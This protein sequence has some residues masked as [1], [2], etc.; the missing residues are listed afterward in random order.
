MHDGTKEDKKQGESI[1]ESNEI[2][3]T[4]VG[5]RQDKFSWAQPLKAKKKGEGLRNNCT[6][7]TEQVLEIMST[8]RLQPHITVQRKKDF[9]GRD[10][11]QRFRVLGG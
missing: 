8:G 11:G 1:C 10:F 6:G 4:T 2:L 7:K 9:E 3:V 5:N